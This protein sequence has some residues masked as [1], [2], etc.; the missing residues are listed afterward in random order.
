MLAF[1]MRRR[2]RRGA[3]AAG[4]STRRRLAAAAAGGGGGRRR[5]RRI[6][7]RRRQLRRRRRV[8]RLVKERRT[9]AADIAASGATSSPTARR[10]R[11][12]FPTAAL[13]RIEAAIAAGEREHRGQVRFAV[14]A[15]LP[16]ARVLRGSR[17]RERALEVFGSAA[18]LGH[19]GEL[20]RAR[21]SAARRPRRRDRRRPRH[22]RAG[23]RRGVGSRSAAR[24]KRR[25]ATAA[26]PKASKRASRE[27]NAL[28]ARHFPRERQPARNELS[29]RPVVL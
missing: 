24:W 19:R 21:L 17:P 15:A 5:R 1:G 22:P 3:A 25:F 26:S 10:V 23:R 18:R 16:L 27:I 7:G 20:R 6:L 8:G 9:Q 13:Q 14:E 2:H 28:L 4:S 29:D 11:R 12:A